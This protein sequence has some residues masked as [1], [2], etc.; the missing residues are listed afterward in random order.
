[1]AASGLIVLASNS[2]LELS[3][4]H[5]DDLTD[6]II[7]AGFAEKSNGEVFY[8]SDGR[9]LT[10]AEMAETLSRIVGGCKI[11]RVPRSVGTIAGFL[12]DSI[13]RLSGRPQLINSQKVKEALQDGWVCNIDKIKNLLGFTPNIGAEAGLESTHLWYKNAGWL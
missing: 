12:G 2:V 9:V 7:L 5:V 11:V 8:I 3:L 13:T 10:V 1:M 6:G 4:I